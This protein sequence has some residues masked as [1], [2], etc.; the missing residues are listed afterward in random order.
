MNTFRRVGLE[1]GQLTDL[2]VEYIDNAVVQTVYPL[3][4][5]RRVFEKSMLPDAGYTKNIFYKET[6][7]GEATVN[8][9]GELQSRDRIELSEAN[10]T[11]PVIAK[12]FKLNWRDILASR[13]RNEP[14]DVAH[15]RNATRQVAEEEDKLLLSG[16]YS[17][18]KALGIEG[19]LSATGRNTDSS[20]GSWATV[21]NIISDFKKAISK[22]TEDGYYGPYWAIVTPAMRNAMLAQLTSTPISILSYIKQ[23]VFDGKGDILVSPNLFVNDD[24]GQDSM[25]V[26][27]P[28]KDNF[29]MLDAMDPTPYMVQDEDMNTLGKVFEVVSPRIKRPASICELAGV[30]LT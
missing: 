22:L 30:S 3:L 21:A 9:T 13:R 10:V 12:G 18:W 28:G 11:I 20:T 5:G 29:D 4:I 15:V 17:G 26:L 8:M 14:L 27:Q 2:E 24:G 7:M 23:E 6:D 19:L 16:E 25:V 1:T